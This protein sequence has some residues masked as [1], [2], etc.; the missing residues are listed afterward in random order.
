VAEQ[1]PGQLIPP[2]FDVTDPLPV[3]LTER[4]WF[5]VVEIVVCAWTGGVVPRSTMTFAV[6]VPAAE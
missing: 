4:D 2:V 5:V 3:T 1:T 6:Y